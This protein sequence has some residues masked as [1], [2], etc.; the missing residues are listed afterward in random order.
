MI[1]AGDVGG[2]KTRLALFDP[3]GDLYKP[4]AEHDFHSGHFPSL[5]EIVSQYLVN[6]NSK[7]VAACFGFAGVARKGRAIAT[8]LPWKVGVDQLSAVIGTEHVWLINDLEA[9]AHGLGVLQKKDFCSI[10]TGVEG[11]PGNIGL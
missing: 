5:E 7:P 1:L 3:D 11:E 9:N 10:N 6:Q 8:N 2:T 4:T